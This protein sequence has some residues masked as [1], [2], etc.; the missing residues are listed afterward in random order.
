[1]KDKMMKRLVCGFLAGLFVFVVLYTGG[2]EWLDR[3]FREAAFSEGAR[4]EELQT[5]AT[6]HRVRASDAGKLKDWAY[7]NQIKELVIVRKGRLLFDLNIQEEVSEKGLPL[8]TNRWKKYSNVIKFADGSANVQLYDGKSEKYYGIFLGVTIIIAIALGITILMTGIGEDMD[9]ICYLEKE[10]TEIGQGDLTRSIAVQGQD[11]LAQL[12]QGLDSMR[13]M[14]VYREEKERE[15]RAAQ[16]KL[17]LG[18]AHDLRTPLTG[19]M[20]YAEVLKKQEKEGKVSREYIDKMF[21]KILQMRALSDQMF[22]YFL[23]FSKEKIELEPPEE[24]ESAF[25]D[26]LSEM[27]ALLECAGF[28]VDAEKVAWKS[29]MVQID[30]NYMGRIINNLFSNIKKYGDMEQSV[31]LEIIYL[32][33]KI[34]VSFTNRTALSDMP[35]ERTGIGLKNVSQMMYQMN[36][37]LEISETEKNFRAVLWFPAAAGTEEEIYSGV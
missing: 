29:V 5:Y 10:V 19:L 35:A 1:M 23:V 34:G 13:K 26:Y 7:R 33:D 9:Y 30:R 37:S 16:D 31:C 24:A 20:T 8:S 36:G 12:A 6:E 22:E 25:G 27:L 2:K 11:E 21:D 4:L 28:S 14:L 18:M 32:T 15:M 3:F 17:V